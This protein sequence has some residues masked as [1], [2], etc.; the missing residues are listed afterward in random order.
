MKDRE[1]GKKREPRFLRKGGER[2]EK[3]DN[4]I[5][6]SSHEATGRDK[7]NRASGNLGTGSTVAKRHTDRQK[8]LL[9][10]HRCFPD[11]PPSVAFPVGPEPD[12]IG[13]PGQCS[14]V[15]TSASD[16]LET[17]GLWP[18][19]APLCAPRRRYSL[20]ATE[21][22]KR[23]QERAPLLCAQSGPRTLG[24]VEGGWKT[25]ADYAA[26]GPWGVGCGLV[27]R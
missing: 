12:S 22:L 4:F 16:P 15:S 1:E 20:R 26:R 17:S 5:A 21:A 24:W 19:K 10:R 23:A 27:S 6:G 18:G 8:G 2:K 9:K 7:V 3:E 13:R 25:M 11:P 14:S